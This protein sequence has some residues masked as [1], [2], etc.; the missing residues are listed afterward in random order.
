M[1]VFVTVN[2]P[3]IAEEVVG[4]KT[5]ATVHE[6]FAA[7]VD[8]QLVVSVK[9]EETVTAV[10]PIAPPLVLVTVNTFAA[11][12]PPA[13]TLPKF[14]VLGVK[15][16]VVSKPTPVSDATSVGSEVESVFTVSVPVRV[17]EAVGANVTLT[18]QLAPSA[19]VVQFEV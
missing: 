12:V 18:V 15:V 9:L 16:A 6:A 13:Y 19:S 7:R 8:P 3:L 17:P 5:T 14:A 2:V 4:A 10:M 11:E 1:L